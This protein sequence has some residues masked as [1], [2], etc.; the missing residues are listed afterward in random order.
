MVKKISDLPSISIVIPSYNK[1]S[2]I[3]ATLQSIVDQKYSNLEIIIHD[4][5]STDGTLEI[6]KSFA[7]KYS[8]LFKWESKKDNGQL[9][10]IN[11]G[12]NKA[13]G[14]V[15]SFINA[16]D[17]FKRGVLLEVG[18]HFKKYPDTVWLTGYG[19]IIDKDGKV[20]SPLVT[21]YKNTLLKINKYSLLLAVNFI[22]QPATFLSK[23]AYE[24]FG[25]FTGTK[26]YVMEY[27]LWL[28]LGKV[29][30]PN[31]IKKTLA[32]FRLTADNISSTASR[33]LLG[34]DYQLVKK[35]T[36]NPFL[37]ALHKLHNLGRI[38]LLNFL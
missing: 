16:D 17:V 11:K 13:T 26:N 36:K 37:L 14:E 27:E 20:I 29:R 5:G 8:Q 28:K 24:Q 7:K 3:R 1:V 4:G 9:D 19:D 25:P 30:M 33:E 12:L 35:Y 21:G 15:L 6:I 34:I 22:T 38:F 18:H 23:K 2:Y 32:S 10:A 31:V